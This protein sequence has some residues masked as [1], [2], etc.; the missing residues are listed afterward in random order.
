MRYAPFMRSWCEEISEMRHPL[1][2]DIH[3][4][5]YAVTCGHPLWLAVS[6]YSLEGIEGMGGPTRVRDAGRPLRW[7]THSGAGVLVSPRAQA[8]V[9]LGYVYA[10]EDGKIV[11]PF[12]ALF[13][14]TYAGAVMPM[15]FSDCAQRISAALMGTG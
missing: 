4:G 5:S 13:G 10:R 8:I 2:A 7:R 15:F 1:G 9:V 14:F 11:P 12:A 3:T 6:I